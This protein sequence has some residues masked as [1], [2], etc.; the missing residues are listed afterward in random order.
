MTHDAPTC[1]FSLMLGVQKLSYISVLIYKKSKWA[2]TWFL[3]YC[4]I[5][6]IFLNCPLSKVPSL[7]VLQ[8]KHETHH[9]SLHILSSFLKLDCFRKFH[10]SFFLLCKNANNI[11]RVLLFLFCVYIVL[12]VLCEWMCVGMRRPEGEPWSWLSLSFE[13]VSLAE[14]SCWS[15]LLA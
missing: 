14:P 11:T 13:A 9:T 12:C 2:L 5:N 10:M 4:L 6:L 8:S 3:L 15:F 1:T 7:L